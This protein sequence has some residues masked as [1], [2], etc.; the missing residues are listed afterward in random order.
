MAAP[1]TLTRAELS[2]CNQGLLPKGEGSLCSC[3]IAHCQCHKAHNVLGPLSTTKL[4]PHLGCKAG[5]S[6]L[7]AWCSQQELGR[8][9]ITIP[10]KP[11]TASENVPTPHQEQTKTSSNF[12]EKPKTL[13]NGLSWHKTSWGVGRRAEVFSSAG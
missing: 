10:T 9:S 1:P 5:S 6:R 13:S 3:G 12:H 7:A 2:S 4:L 11:L 8:K